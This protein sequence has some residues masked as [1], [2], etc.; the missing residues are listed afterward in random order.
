MQRK[1]QSYTSE[2][3]SCFHLVKKIFEKNNAYLMQLVRKGKN[4]DHKI[5]RN[6]V[7]DTSKFYENTQKS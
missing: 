6:N 1:T 3:N 2:V 7:P 5:P 4:Q